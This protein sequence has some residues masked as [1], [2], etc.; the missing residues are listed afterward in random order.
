MI[1]VLA[2]VVTHC[3][4]A[5][6]LSRI[7]DVLVNEHLAACVHVSGPITSTYRWNGTVEQTS[8]HELVAVTS[9]TGVAAVAG[10]ITDMHPYELPSIVVRP[11]T[12]SEDYAAWVA[13]ET[14]T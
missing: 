3:D 14:G 1:A 11:V 2:E 8:E 4:D 12:A 10:R 6:A 5:D 9:S 7:A 13:A